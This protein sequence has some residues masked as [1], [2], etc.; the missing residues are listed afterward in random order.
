MKVKK[1]IPVI[2]KRKFDLSI[3]SDFLFL[4]P[5]IKND[6]FNFRNVGHNLLEWVE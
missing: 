4:H 2:T 1:E 6:I 3:L 5:K